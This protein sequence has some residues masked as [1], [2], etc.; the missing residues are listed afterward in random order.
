MGDCP[1]NCLMDCIEK[2]IQDKPE[3]QDNLDDTYRATPNTVVIRSG[4]VRASVT[5]PAVQP[6]V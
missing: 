2:D 5:M 4:A 3:N 6:N 1:D